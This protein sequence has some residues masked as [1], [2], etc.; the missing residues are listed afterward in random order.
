MVSFT[1]CVQTRRRHIGDVSKT[2]AGM[3][4]RRNSLRA[5]VVIIIRSP[6]NIIIVVIVA[7][8]CLRELQNGK[9]N[10]KSLEKKIFPPQKQRPDQR[11]RANVARPGYSR[12]TSVTACA[13]TRARQRSERQ[14]PQSIAVSRVMPCW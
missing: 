9:E 6:Y 7:V 8:A 13:C 1:R 5:A 14:Q 3:V 12:L 2:M 10:T 4:F 11:T